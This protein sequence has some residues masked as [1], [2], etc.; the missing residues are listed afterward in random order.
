MKIQIIQF[1]DIHFKEKNNSLLQKKDQLFDAL[2]NELTDDT[3]LLVSGDSAFSGT[4]SEFNIANDFYSE[5]IRKLNDYSK[6]EVKLIIIP[7]NHDCQDLIEKDPVRKS[8]LDVI[9][10]P[11]T[12]SEI[13]LI[14]VISKNLSN[15]YSFEEQ[16]NRD[17]DIIY[18][19][20][21]LKV[22]KLEKESKCILFY[23]YNTAFQSI[24]HEIPGKMIFPL[25]LIEDKTFQIKADLKI[26]CLHHP[27]HWL[28]PESNR[29]FKSHIER[30]SDF[31]FTGHEHIDSKS[32]MSDL[33]DNFVYHIE[34]D[35]L[36]D[37]ETENQSGFNL[38]N[39][40]FETNLFQVKNFKW[41]G[42]RYKESENIANWN[43]LKRGTLKIN[44]PYQLTE[45]F[46]AK[47]NDIGANFSHPNISQVKL[48]DIYV[49]PNLELLNQVE[50]DKENVSVLTINSE[51]LLNN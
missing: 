22:Y 5:V 29:N 21:I 17:L 36:Q 3:I 30:T 42:E 4:K 44:N 33:E 49:Y 20:E 15:Y 47:L 45:T 32:L 31:Y 24:L 26:S 19:S 14:R 25:D 43:S 16:S 41:N 9:Q 12:T 23:C 38:V 28:N 34:G 46:K 6:K 37:S 10:K 39:V 48:S 1:S 50:E 2:K 27:F 7:G 13:E 35:V 8:L 11:Q 51:D 18:T 40:N